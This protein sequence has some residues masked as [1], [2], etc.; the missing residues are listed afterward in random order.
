[1]ILDT[2]GLSAVA[3]GDPAI[4]PA[5]RRADVV[6]IPVVVLGEYLYG[7][8]GSRE[9]LRYERW[10]TQWMPTYRVLDV[11]QAT[12]RHYAEIR[13]QLKSRGRPIPSNDLWIAALTVQHATSEHPQPGDLVRIAFAGQPVAVA[14]RA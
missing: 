13:E 12:A 7:I 3:D 1:M 8:R 5:L 10:L 4:E 11:D 14:P 2:N 9:R 6:A